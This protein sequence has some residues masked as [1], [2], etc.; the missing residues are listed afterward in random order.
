MAANQ[1]CHVEQS[2][3]LLQNNICP[4]GKKGDDKTILR[5]KMY[6]NRGRH[7]WQQEEG[8]WKAR[9]LPLPVDLRMYTPKTEIIFKHGTM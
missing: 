7:C 3:L 1:I 4:S 2:N 5:A 9:Y 8:E 6:D